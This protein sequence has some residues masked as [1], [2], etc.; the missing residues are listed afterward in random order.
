MGMV[1]SNSSTNTTW[2]CSTELIYTWPFT[3]FYAASSASIERLSWESCDSINYQNQLKGLRG[4]FFP[5]CWYTSAPTVAVNKTSLNSGS[6]K[7]LTYRFQKSN[8]Y[9]LYDHSLQR[10][11]IMLN[12]AI[13]V[14][15]RLLSLLLWYM[16]I[17]N[18][19]G[20]RLTLN[21]SVSSTL[22]PFIYQSLV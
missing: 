5:V 6:Y 8:E 9:F 10:N 22:S 19:R 2:L 20:Q 17:V 1:L 16:A 7:E 14:L 21:R 4:W 15:R 11:I 12:T 18:S 13:F 3:S